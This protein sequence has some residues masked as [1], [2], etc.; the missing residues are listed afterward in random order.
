[1]GPPEG[2]SKEEKRRIGKTLKG[3]GPEPGGMD[4]ANYRPRK[5]NLEALV[6]TLVG[7]HVLM[8]EGLARA[9]EAASRNDYE[10]VRTEL[11][12]LDPVFRQHI[13]DEESQILGLLIGEL[14]AKG[15]AE[16][17]KVFRQHRPIYLLM[18]KADELASMSASGLEA[19]QAELRDLFDRHARAE[20]GRVFPRARSLSAGPAARA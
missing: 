11:K 7:E 3:G 10:A 18:K 2:R 20:E 16:E 8:G 13:A 9:R 5:M 17:I 6:A 15:A 14:G 19:N 12:K 1:M 4:G